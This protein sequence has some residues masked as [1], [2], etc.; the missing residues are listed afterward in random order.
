M[1]LGTLA[2]IVGL[3]TERTNM[4]LILMCCTEILALAGIEYFNV[5]GLGLEC[6]LVIIITMIGMRGEK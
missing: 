6:A 4:K 5:H 3:L 2:C 1:T